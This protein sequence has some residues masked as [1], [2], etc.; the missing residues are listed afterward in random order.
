MDGFRIETPFASIE[1]AL[2]LAETALADGNRA[3]LLRSSVPRRRGP[4]VADA[5][6]HS[7]RCTVMW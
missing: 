4:N 6:V 3:L 5:R 1:S 7:C 2:L